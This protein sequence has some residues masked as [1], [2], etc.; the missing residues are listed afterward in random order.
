MILNLSQPAGIYVLSVSYPSVASWMISC[1]GPVNT[2]IFCPVINPSASSQ[3]PLMVSYGNEFDWCLLG[4][5]LA[6]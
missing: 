3:L 2:S 5:Y 1:P 4:R 6:L